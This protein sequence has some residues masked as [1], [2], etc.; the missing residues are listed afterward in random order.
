MGMTEDVARGGIVLFGGVEDFLGGKIFGD[1]WTWD[2]I[3]WTEHRSDLRPAKRDD[4][5][6][7]YSPTLQ[8]VVLFGGTEY[9]LKWYADTWTWD[10]S[11]WAQG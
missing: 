1:T 3:G 10:G 8:R 9:G 5:A 7:A 11:V 4:M 2:G 6:M